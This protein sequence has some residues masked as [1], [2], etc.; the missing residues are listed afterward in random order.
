M[1][2]GM[3]PSS[4]QGTL[5]LASFRYLL[6]HPWQLALTIIGIALGIAII[7]AV[8]LANESA[9][10]AFQLS[11]ENINGKATHQIVGGPSGLDEQ[12]YTRLRIELGVRD[13]APLVEAYGVSG[14]ETLH[15]IGFDP[16]ANLGQAARFGELEGGAMEDLIAVPNTAL[17][18]APTARRMELAVGDTFEVELGGRPQ[19]LR[20]IGLLELRDQPEAAIE[21]LLLT[22]ISTAQEITGYVGRLS[23]IDLVIEDD[24]GS[25]LLERIR[26]ILP[27]DAELVPAAS[28]ANAMAQMSRAFRTNLMA[29]GL[30]ALI[31][32]MFLVY[33][34]MTFMVIQRCHLLATLRML[35]VSRGELFRVVLGEALLIGVI[36][37][38]A[39]LAIGVLLGM[40][41]VHLVTRTI[42]DLYFVVT[43]TDLQLTLAPIAK[44]ALLGIGG[45]LAAAFIPTL[46]AAM[47]SPHAAR[48]RSMLE[49]HTH[50]FVTRL[51]V[52]G[53][54]L[55]AA[56]LLLLAIPS[57]ALMLGFTSLF[58]LVLGMT[59]LV[60]WLV[61]R[62]VA[63][64]NRWGTGRLSVTTRLAI[65]GIAD[66][67]SRTGTAIAALMLAV[68]TTIGVSVMIDSFRSSVTTWLEAT[69]RADIFLSA[70]S[71][72][73]G[74]SLSALDSGL[75]Q[76][77]E[78][79]PEVTG[80]SQGR[81]VTIE[82]EGQLTK[83]FALKL[84]EN[85]KP[86]FQLKEGDPGE[87][88]PAYR[89]GEAVLVSEP[90]AYHRGLR[91]GDTIELRTDHGPQRFP[92]AGVYYD[93]GSEQ[94]KV[95]MARSLYNRHYRDR[96]VGGLGLYIQPG[97][98]PEAVI[99]KVRALANDVGQQIRIRSNRE[100]R[101]YTLEVFDRTFAI[102]HVLRLLAI[103]V[104]FIGILTALMA[105]QLERAKE[106]AVLRAT[107]VTPGEVARIITIQTGAMG[108]LAGLLAIPTG[109]VL[110]QV[111]I[112]V[113][114]KRSFG[115]SME[116]L[117]HFNELA[118]AIVLAVVA[119]LLAAVYP[120]WR[121]THTAPALAL[122]EE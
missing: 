115:W 50:V 91:A 46:E 93:Y 83:L 1:V 81:Q 97:A 70:P 24:E 84:A 23:W 74:R 101:A 54:V 48:R 8:D 94:G 53:L 117:I 14:A 20:L 15:L 12:V 10:R 5:R 56:G 112:H 61:M 55:F 17:L 90:L 42:N 78:A 7:V 43:V 38:I 75:I 119:A 62:C 64:S 39:G 18:A 6:Q 80:V 29:M 106:I 103:L 88:W 19:R 52:A 85:A 72:G 96:D 41:L 25:G 102:T 89:R 120:S 107:G 113:I 11:M 76:A 118:A 21:G 110:S 47:T 45:T 99:R 26:A 71:L 9:T 63:L 98:D 68:A 108:L 100:I 122:R 59:F 35:G 57:K 36:A 44:A 65:R 86:G 49:A 27:P 73:S 77:I 13:S 40:G 121:M 2:T 28:R 95:L 114:N 67:L 37:T 116:S 31:V 82:S 92:I 3:A 22:D 34:T 109:L 16:I 33:N 104:A 87:V 60:P 4:G 32:G 105:L 66:A 79:L 69:M 58:L 30:M 111:L 51:F